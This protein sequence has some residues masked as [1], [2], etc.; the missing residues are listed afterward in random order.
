MKHS[1]Q[2]KTII[3]DLFWHEKHGTKNNKLGHY[4]LI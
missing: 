1:E 3:H 2:R 4:L